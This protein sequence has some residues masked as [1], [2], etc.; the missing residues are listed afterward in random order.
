[1]H[2]FTSEHSP[3]NNN[4]FWIDGRWLIVGNLLSVNSPTFEL[5]GVVCDVPQNK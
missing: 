1:M 3:S 5:R 4:N 2:A